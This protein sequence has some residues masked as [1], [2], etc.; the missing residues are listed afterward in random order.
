MGSLE[1]Q[2]MHYFQKKTGFSVQNSSLEIVNQKGSYDIASQTAFINNDD[3]LSSFALNFIGRGSFIENSDIGL[4]MKELYGTKELTGYNNS[5]SDAMMPLVPFNNQQKYHGFALWTQDMLLSKQN[6]EKPTLADGES[7]VLDYLK[8]VDDKFG[9]FCFL[10]EMGFPRD[11]TQ[12]SEIIELLRKLGYKL[13]KDDLVLLYGSKN[14]RSDI[15]LFVLSDMDTNQG[16]SVDY[17][18]WLDIYQLNKSSVDSYIE[19]LDYSVVDA[20]F[21]G[22]AIYGGKNFHDTLKNKVLSQPIE[23]SAI[24]Y[25]LKMGKKREA[26]LLANP[27]GGLRNNKL[28]K[29][30]MIN[31]LVHAKELSNGRKNL[32]Y[33]ELKNCYNFY[34]FSSL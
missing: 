20:L 16:F 21:T 2:L 8:D 26:D 33:K 27:S 5:I 4:K 23:N 31:Y 11:H 10:N 1:N 6:R 29:S 28:R 13:E 25:N 22:E 34:G 30:N 24:E 18:G 7:L 17:M 15:D 9:R 3:F 19:V 32:S 12:H 14:P